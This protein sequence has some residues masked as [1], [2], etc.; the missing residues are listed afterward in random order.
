MSAPNPLQ[1]GDKTASLLLDLRTGR[2][3]SP[4]AF[5]PGDTIRKAFARLERLGYI[6]LAG[7]CDR[8]TDTGRAWIDAQHL[9]VTLSH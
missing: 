1:P 4:G 8:I 3:F 7:G 6:T 9:R 5:Y 2:G